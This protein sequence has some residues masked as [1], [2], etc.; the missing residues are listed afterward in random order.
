MEHR[1]CRPH[2]SGRQIKMFLAL[3]DVGPDGGPN[4][5]S[6][7]CSTVG[8]PQCRSNVFAL[9]KPHH[10]TLTQPHRWPDVIPN[11]CAHGWPDG[12]PDC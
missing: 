6:H 2:W 8:S 10:G 12:G 5:G 9:S 4:G 11:R 1:G 3:S 7:D